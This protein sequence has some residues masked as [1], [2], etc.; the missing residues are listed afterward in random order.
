VEKPRPDRVKVRFRLD[1]D[2]DGWPPFESE[3]VW[4]NA[5]GGRE[6]E[7]D[8]APWFARGVAFGDRVRAE[9]DEDGV[10]WVRGR[11]AWSE[12]FAVA[13]RRHNRRSLLGASLRCLPWHDSMHAPVHARGAHLRQV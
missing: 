5:C 13:W 11:L 2:G 9:P 10:L 12:G 8:N 1:R 3:G 4:A 7:V 6:Y